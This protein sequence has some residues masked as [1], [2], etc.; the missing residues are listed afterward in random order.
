[1]F[2]IHYL[3]LVRINGS[4]NL[5][6]IRQLVRDRRVHAHR[7]L[8]PGWS[9]SAIRLLVSR[10]ISHLKLGHWHIY[11]AKHAR[12]LVNTIHLSARLLQKF[13]VYRLLARRGLLLGVAQRNVVIAQY[14]GI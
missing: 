3:G 9:G 8:H 2:E 7:G 1:M 11:S 14:R 13:I 6:H 10:L 12:C 5:I 4:H